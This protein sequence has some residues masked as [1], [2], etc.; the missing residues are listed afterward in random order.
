LNELSNNGGYVCAQYRGYEACLIGRVSPG[1]P[2]EPVYAQWRRSSYDNPRRPAV[3]KTVR[4]DRVKIVSPLDHAVLLVGRPIRGT[5]MRWPNARDT[6]RAL[7]EGEPLSVN[8]G[9]LSPDQQEIMCS[10]FLRTPEATAMGLP[11]LEHLLLPTGRT[12]KDL[13]I[14]G[15]ASDGHPLCA[16]VTLA[17]RVQAAWKLER[18]K[19]YATDSSAHL[20]L[21]CRTTEAETANGVH[22]RSIEEVFRCFRATASGRRWIAR[23]LQG[24]LFAS[25]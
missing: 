14:L 6:I 5:F 23:A 3:L 24:A 7:V 12:L 16:Q 25:D 13:D 21:F 2:I 19:A 22:V 15:I 4:L 10:E 18:M 9:R 17:D 20:I 1:T 8:V 11:R